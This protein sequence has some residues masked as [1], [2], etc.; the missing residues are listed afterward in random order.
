MAQSI[1]IAGASYP[2]VP[3]I[4]VPKVGSGTAGFFDVSDTT[5]AAADVA[6]GKYF[7]AA[8]G[9]RT[10]GTASG[11]GGGTI[12]E[13]WETPHPK[14]TVALKDTDFNTWTPSTTSKNIY[15]G[16]AVNSS[17]I[18]LDQ[19]VY[20]VRFQF[21]FV[22]AYV[23]NATLV[24]QISKSSEDTWYVMY[25]GPASAAEMISGSWTG[26]LR[27][28]LSSMLYRT[29]YDTSG[30]L[31]S[32]TSQYGIYQ[33][34]ITAPTFTTDG[35]IKVI[36]PATYARCYASYFSTSAAGE[37]DKTNSKFTFK[38]SV[39]RAAVNNDIRKIYCGWADGF[40]DGIS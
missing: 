38:T 17:I 36:R 16:S 4:V 22:P 12:L 31:A 24:A 19:Y 14:T 34:T 28:T 1:Q 15:A 40:I 21:C 11:G 2:D 6:Q 25:K 37:L 3:S 23:A 26:K 39:Y 13:L 7:Y 35:K 9:T 10:Q 27:T 5:A 18:D 20:F 8:D 30:T 32:I 33:T 29:Y